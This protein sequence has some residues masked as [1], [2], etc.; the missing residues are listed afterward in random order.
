M[1]W[2]LV[3]RLIDSSILATRLAAICWGILETVWNGGDK[4]II[5]RGEGHALSKRLLL[6]IVKWETVRVA[7]KVH[8]ILKQAANSPCK[9]KSFARV[10]IVNLG[11]K[12]GMWGDCEQ[13]EVGR[14]VLQLVDEAWWGDNTESDDW[15]V[16][17][18]EGCVEGVCI[19]KWRA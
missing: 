9:D 16:S 12:D 6:H 19:A 15:K 7:W 8:F 17:V 13:G 14:R 4:P 5:P 1:S 11:V 10:V 2:C 18:S 3:N